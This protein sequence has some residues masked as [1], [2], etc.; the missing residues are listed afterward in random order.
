M[1]ILD[2]DDVALMVLLLANLDPN[3]Y[4]SDGTKALLYR[5]RSLIE[6]NGDGTAYI[7][8]FKIS[9]S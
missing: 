5:M 7:K 9:K 6:E 1:Q 8:P 2:E 4:K 3:K